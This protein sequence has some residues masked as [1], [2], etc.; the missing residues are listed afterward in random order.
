MA[1]LILNNDQISARRLSTMV[2]RFAFER[3][4]TARLDDLPHSLPQVPS[5]I[6]C[7]VKG[8]MALHAVLRS[9]EQNSLLGSVPVV[10]IIDDCFPILTKLLWKYRRPRLSALLST[11]FSQ[12][13]LF[14]G[15]LRALRNEHRKTAVL[16][17]VAKSES[18]LA[19][20]KLAAN[21]RGAKVIHLASRPSRE[22]LSTASA[23]LVEL[24]A[25]SESELTG[26]SEV[27]RSSR[28]NFETVAVGNDPARGIGLRNTCENFIGTPQSRRDWVAMLDDVFHLRQTQWVRRTLS[29]HWKKAHK[30]RDFPIMDAIAKQT[31]WLKSPDARTQTI[32]GELHMAKGEYLQ[33]QRCFEASLRRNPFHPKTYWMLFRYFGNEQPAGTREGWEAKFRG[34]CPNLKFSKNP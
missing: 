7:R 32:L 28:G 19:S 34:C 4:I 1:I 17:V 10:G 21:G 26:L 27:F 6:L 16:G 30:K 18:F 14:F 23:V 31:I 25:F 29:R 13:E 33:S 15:M 24:D 9:I 2:A 5:F 12:R 3:I 20:A 11:P 22:T 8:R